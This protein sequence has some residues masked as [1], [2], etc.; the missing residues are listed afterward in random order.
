MSSSNVCAHCGEHAKNRCAGC[1][2]YN[3]ATYYCSTDHQKRHWRTHKPVCGAKAA[4]APDPTVAAGASGASASATT[5]SSLSKCT[6]CLQPCDGAG[7]CRVPHPVH[8]RQDMGAM[9]GPEGMRQF[10]ACGACNKQYT[11]TA[12]FSGGVVHSHALSFRSRLSKRIVKRLH[13]CTEVDMYASMSG[14]TYLA[15]VP[16][17]L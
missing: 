9:S 1:K 14:R 7:R 4:T 2:R 8:L 15:S 5:T 16:G 13:S 6:R 10:Y 11:I 3:I 17:T 12:E